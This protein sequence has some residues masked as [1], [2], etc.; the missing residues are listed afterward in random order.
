MSTSFGEN[1]SA[2]FS[3][4]LQYAHFYDFDAKVHN[5][6]EVNL[7]TVT[8]SD[9]TCRCNSGAAASS[10]AQINSNGV[11]SYRPGQ[12]VT[13]RWASIFDTPVEGNVQRCG[14]YD[15]DNGV[16][17]GYDSLGNFG[18][19]VRR[20]GVDTFYDQ[21]SWN[22][23]T[24]AIGSFILDHQKGNIYEIKMQYFGFGNLFLN[25]ENQNGVFETIHKI[26]HQ[27]SSTT[28]SLLNANLGFRMESIN[29]SNDT[30]IVVENACYA[31]FVEGNTYQLGPIVAASGS[32]MSVGTT[33]TNIL[34]IR[35][36]STFLGQTNKS[37]LKVLMFNT[38]SDGNKSC[39]VKFVLNATLTTPSYSLISGT[40]V[41]EDTTGTYS[42]GGIEMLTLNMSNND[43]KLYNTNMYEFFL[44]VGATLSMIGAYNNSGTGDLNCSIVVRQD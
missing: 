40:H 25:I 18:L 36:S 41:E 13:L 34:T 5:K 28:T 31:A 23:N 37:H 33:E 6:S 4:R 10:S 22:V 17:V 35:N 14:F 20:G 3:S 43:S 9:G 19:T 2:E 21:T 15:N 7:G 11:V 8:Y 44:P 39:Y 16:F 42:G 32:K 1:L 30:D 26:N 38:S 24:L 27:N 12:G 29:T